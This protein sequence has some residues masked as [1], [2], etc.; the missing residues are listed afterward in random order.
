MKQ[1]EVSEIIERAKNEIKILV[2]KYQKVAE[3]KRITK[4]NEEMTKAEFIE[5]LFE[6]LGWDIRNK[7][8]KDEVTREEQISK[9]RVDYSFRINGIPKFFLEAKPLRAN[10][11]DP[12]YVEQA[13]H[14]AW[15]KGCTWAVLTDFEAVKI[16]NAEWRTTSYSQN[17]I[18]TIPCYEFLDRFSELWLLSKDSFEKGLLDKEAEKWG[19]KTKKSPVDKQ[20]LS[21]FTHFREILS[22]SITKLNQTKNVSQE[23][24]DESIQRILDRLIFIRNCE[25]R[26]LEERQ[27]ISNLRVWEDKGKGQLVKNLREVFSYFDKLYNGRIFTKHLCDDL[28]VDNEI[29]HEVIEGLYYTKDK[30]IS[31]D[32][33]A[34]EADV[35]GNIYEQYLG[36]ILKKTAKRATLTESQTHRKEQGIFYTPTYI[37]DYIVRHT[38]GK[39]LETKKIDPLKIRVLDPACGS[40]SFLIKAFDVMNNYHMKTDKDYAQTHL[41]VDAGN[42]TYTKKLNILKNNIFGVD[43]DRQ[44]IEVAHLNLLLKITEKGHRLPLL[45]QNIKQG[46]SIVSTSLSEKDKAF[47]WE[48]EFPEITKNDKGFDVIIGNPPYVRQEELLPIKSFLQSNYEV[49]HSMADLFVYFFEREIKLLKEGGYLGMIVSN[50]WLKAGY[51]Q[52]LRKFLNK[53]WIEEFI[54]FGDLRVFQDATTYPCIIIIRKIN[55][56]NPKIKT[57]LV[58]NLNF[59]SLDDYVKENGFTFDQQNLDEKG[60]TIQSNKTLNL[61]DEMESQSI[62]LKEYVNDQY[63]RGIITGLTEAFVVDEEKKDEFIKRDPKSA[64]IIRPFLTGKEVRRYGVNFQN[65]YIILTKIGVDIKKYPTIFNW[66]SKFQKQL[67]ERWDKGNY[68]YELRACDYYELFEKPK[69]IYGVITVSPRFT[70]DTD[71]YLANNANFF[72]PTDDKHLLAILNSKLGWFLITKKCTQVQGG[73][74]LIWKYFGNVPISKK[75]DPEIEKMV[76]KMLTLNKK[77]IQLGNKMTDERMAIENEIKKLDAE[78]DEHVYQLYNL[79]SN[80]IKLIEETVS[81]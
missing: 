73:Y 79:D 67:E 4:Y 39:L 26:G 69:I 1:A 61:L 38:L 5:P 24:L 34:I 45:Q 41:D 21:D 2:E 43:L 42:G 10:L 28:E 52:N 22:K 16:F 15:N 27:L 44:A 20:L 8:H 48:V 11:D 6:A 74:Q 13:I 25:D 35:L 58:E 32:F 77:L 47:N 17:H 59:S 40:G 31:Y 3:E 18:K 64:E 65:K 46:N 62:P 55:K 63:Y 66:L 72:I 23:E 68:W 80:E 9:D 60:W 57:C 14:Y 29:L 56:Q 7:H 50:K 70:I 49:Y 71:G 33:S 30:S 12:K 19:K 81:K 37:V 51:A 78:I 76:D 36:H 75:K 54:D 53:Y